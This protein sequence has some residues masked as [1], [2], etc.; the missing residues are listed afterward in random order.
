MMKPVNV[1]KA[2]SNRELSTPRRTAKIRQTLL[3]VFLLNLLVAIAKLSYG[4]LSGSLSMT[5]D[6]LNSLM[7]G[8]ANV[9][10][11]IG[12]AI[13]ARPPDPNHPY[14]HRR[15]ET[16][17]ALAIA[18]AMVLAVVQIVQEAWNRWQAGAAPEVTTFSFAIMGATLLVNVGVTL[19]ERRRARELHSS[20]LGAD[21]K[22]TAADALVSLSVIGGLAAVQLGF[23]TADLLLAVAV[24]GVI[25]W[26]A[27]TIM[28]DAALTL[29]DVAAA[30]VEVIERAARTVPGVRGVH[31]IRTRGGEG[32]VWVDLHVQVDPSLRVEQAHEIASAVAAR[33]EEEIGQP[34]DVTVHI[35]P[36]TGRHL[37]PT[38]GYR[39]WQEER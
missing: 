35:E 39:P 18:M 33:V 28:R 30:P 22:H 32:L 15:F 8:A 3:V 26:G 2:P 9:V 25:A 12:L 7:D 11:L 24:A 19:W 27:W 38:R 5:A 10:G 37:R 13:A 36:A 17:T 16:I 34:S 20:I 6:G 23:P 1:D 4:L 31:N 29:S 21:A 14:G